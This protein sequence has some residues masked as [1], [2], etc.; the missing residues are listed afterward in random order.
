MIVALVGNWKTLAL[1]GAAAVLFGL[2]TLV[3]PDVTL[4][5]LVLLFGAWAFVDGVFRLVALATGVPG[6]RAHRTALII[7]GI[8]GVGIG[9]VTFIWPDMTALAL[10]F[11]IAAWAFVIG[12]VEVAAA[13]QLRKVIENEWLLGLKGALAIIFAIVLVITPGAGA[14]V[15]T[16]LIGWFALLSGTLRLALAW[17]LRK[18]EK[19]TVELADGRLRA[20]PA[21]T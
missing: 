12:V 21:A 10:L 5:A 18:L 17:K 7:Q 20:R 16:W 14:L 2:L 9:I 13:V 4:W 3:W 6:A 1:G 11:V 15:I 8:L 19:G